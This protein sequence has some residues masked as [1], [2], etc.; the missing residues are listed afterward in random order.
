[1]RSLGR[2]P[3]NYCYNTSGHE[4]KN[5][6]A[7]KGAC[8]ESKCFVHGLVDLLNNG[9]KGNEDKFITHDIWSRFTPTE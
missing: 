8:D 1:M 6:R 7:R 5:D 9:N 2:S 3:L 4:R